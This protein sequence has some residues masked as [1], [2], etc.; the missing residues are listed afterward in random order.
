MRIGSYYLYLHLYDSQSLK[1]K[2]RVLQSFFDHTRQKF[3]V[4]I[5]EVGAYDLWNASEVGI[6]C[7]ANET[8][9]VQKI[10]DQVLNFCDSFHEFEITQVDQEIL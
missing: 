8:A 4:S 5:S 2:R 3:N 9:Q 7:V 10:L 6:A 1:D